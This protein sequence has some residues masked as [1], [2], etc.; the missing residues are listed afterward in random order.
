MPPHPTLYPP[1]ILALVVEQHAT[2]GAHLIFEFYLGILLHTY[3]DCE[4]PLAVPNGTLF[5]WGSIC[6]TRTARGL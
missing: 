1:T 6:A 5:G 3:L 2:A 4:R